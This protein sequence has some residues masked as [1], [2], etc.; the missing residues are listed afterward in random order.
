MQ[1]EAECD[2]VVVIGDILPS[3]CDLEWDNFLVMDIG[4][5]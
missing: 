2:K 5:H 3:A 1:T 4:I